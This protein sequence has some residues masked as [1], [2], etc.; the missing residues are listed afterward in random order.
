VPPAVCC[1]PEA[2]P[3]GCYTVNECLNLH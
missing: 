3:V 2:K 1:Q